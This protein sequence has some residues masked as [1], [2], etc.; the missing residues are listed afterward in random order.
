MKS[1]VR[2][3]P[4][5]A[6]VLLIFGAAFLMAADIHFVQPGSLTVHEWGTFTSVAGEDGAAVDW[7]TLGC[8]NDLP[9]FVNDYGYRGFKFRLQGSVRMETPVLY[10]YSPRELDAHVK[11]SF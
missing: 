10:F 8:K 2:F 11:V 6:P 7:D 4:V 1:A 5:V 3:V 9:R